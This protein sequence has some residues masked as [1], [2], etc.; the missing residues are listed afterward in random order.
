MG[1]DLEAPQMRKLKIC[2]PVEVVW[3]DIE[4]DPAWQDRDSLARPP[5]TLCH[6]VGYVIGQDRDFL[7]VTATLGGEKQQPGS[8]I[9]IPLGCVRSVYAVGVLRDVLYKAKG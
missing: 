8:R 2:S 3:V 1:I 9:S 7:Y 4:E 6:T 5:D